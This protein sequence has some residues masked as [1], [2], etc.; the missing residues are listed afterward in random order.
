MGT[1][2]GEYSPL[3]AISATCGNRLRT[4]DKAQIQT[5]AADS[6]LQRLNRDG[7][8]RK[9]KVPRICLGRKAPQNRGHGVFP[10]LGEGNCSHYPQAERDAETGTRFACG[11]DN[12]AGVDNRNP[13][14]L[15]DRSTL[16]WR[17]IPLARSSEIGSPPEFCRDFF[18]SA[19]GEFRLPA[20][21]KDA[22][23]G[24]WLRII[25]VVLVI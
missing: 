1:V 4:M 5:C 24:L 22:Q 20:R 7:P 10:R 19:V 13:G 2:T 12:A 8:P 15:S 9:I 17:K 16:R 11:H 25:L 6:V 3:I 21:L 23:K 14:L 18:P